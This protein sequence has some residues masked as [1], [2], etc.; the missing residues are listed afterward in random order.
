MKK[1]LTSFLILFSI[2]FR[3]LADEGMWIPILL[4]QGPEAEMKRLGMKISAEDIFNLNKP[5]MKDAI[6][7]FGGGCTAE[8]VSDKGLILT[9][10]HCGYSAVQAHSS[11]EQDYLTKGFWAQS[12]EEELSNPKLKVSILTYMEDVTSRVLKNI[13]DNISTEKRKALIELQIDAIIKENTK[14]NTYEVAVEPFYYGN[15]FILIISRIYKDVRLVGAPP[16]GIGKFGGDT[17]NWV[18]PRHTGDFSVFRIYVDK[19]NNPAEYSKDNIPYT[20]SYHLTISL[21][22]VQPGDFTFVFGYP[23]TTNEYLVSYAVD[24]ISN[25]ENPAAIKIRGKK[26]EVI[27]KYMEQSNKTRIQYSSKYFGIENYYKKMIGESK[28]VK[29]TNIIAEKQGL[30]KKF[31][32]WANA[33]PDRQKK[34]DKLMERFEELY[35]KYGAYN[36]AA[37]YV[38]EAGLGMEIIRYA[39]SYENLIKISLNKKQNDDEINKNLERLKAS[40]ESFFKNYDSRI[41]HELMSSLLDIYYNGLDKSMIPAEIVRAGEA[42]NGDFEK[43]SADLFKRSFMVEENKVK[44]FL[45]NYKPSK[46]KEIEKDPAY[47][48]AISIYEFYRNNLYSKSEEFQAKADEMYRIY[49]QGL[50]EMMPEKKFYP[51]A[52]S[53]LRVAYGQ[54]AGFEPRD[55]VEYNYFTTLKG[56]IEKEDSTIYDYTID[57]K[58]ND[59]YNNKDYGIYADKDGSMHVAFI[60]TNHTTGGNSGS[61]VLNADG[62]LIGINFDRVWEGTMS[63]IVFEPAMCRNISLDI[64]YCLFII[65]KYAG[66]HRLIDEMTLEK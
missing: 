3:S 25:Y 65:D 5:S 42:Y 30:E 32:A 39:A 38:Y 29:R 6:C 58:L 40:S 48:L 61:P 56:V 2:C 54:V 8:I 47:M 27:R 33:D 53:T 9:N 52:N 46:A 36:L 50:M 63:D 14:D 10:H 55:A 4:S 11:V 49:M 51:D 26:L 22:G 31:T 41:D 28:G 24:R 45:K 35:K 17:D 21:K 64:R 20:P 13:P 34:Y 7:L 19:D 62:H 66:A 1:I 18:W 59:L 23:G 12:L 15:Q 16:S 60:A 43:Y 57:N 37:E 44:E